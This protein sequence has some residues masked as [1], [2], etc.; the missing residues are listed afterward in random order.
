MAGN[1]G[2]KAGNIGANRRNYIVLLIFSWK[3]GIL[4]SVRA[5]YD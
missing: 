4:S 5:K 2:A 3:G 1:I